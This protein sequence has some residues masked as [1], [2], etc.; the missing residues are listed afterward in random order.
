MIDI[1]ILG[2]GGGIPMPNR[3]LSASLISYLGRKILIDAGEGTQVSIKIAGTGFK[4]IDIICITHY[5]GDHIVG[6]SGL[7]ATIG[8]S[9]RVEPITIIG[10]QGIK[11][12]VSSLNIINPY[13]PYN[14]NFIENPKESIYFKIEKNNSILVHEETQSNVEIKALPLEHSSECLGY[15][16]YY[17]R[18]PKFSVEKAKENNVPKHLWK[19]LQQGDSIEFEEVLYKPFMVN[20]ERRRGVKVSYISDTRPIEK[21][22]DFIK[23]SD[24]F[25]CEGNYGSNED[26]DKAIKNKHMTFS[27]GATL[28]REAKVKELIL[29][30]FSPAISN[31]E[32]YLDNAK[33]IF[34]DTVLAKDGMIKSLKYND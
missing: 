28:A 3:F 5:H 33:N 4:S 1:C 21:I 19:L 30:H 15:N 22:V 13:L 24:L 34:K 29:T 20:G 26:L 18:L 9:G 25:I 31:P 12:V 7:L 14:I 16:F 8:N 10:P 6:L 2:T 23:E 32:D 27:E 17:K 11:E